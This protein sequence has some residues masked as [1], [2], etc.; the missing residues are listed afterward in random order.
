MSGSNEP[1]RGLLARRS[2]DAHVASANRKHSASRDPRCVIVYV[3]SINDCTA[4]GK[5][6]AIPPCRIQP[7]GADPER[8]RKR[9]VLRKVEHEVKRGHRWHLGIVDLDYD[10]LRGIPLSPCAVYTDSHD[11][12]TMALQTDALRSALADCLVFGEDLTALR[13]RLQELAL[14]IG[15][16][17]LR[18]LKC[19]W[20]VPFDMLSR[21]E[22]ELGRICDVRTGR[23]DHD[24]LAAWVHPRITEPHRSRHTV[25][26][27]RELAVTGIAEEDPWEV[28]HGHDMTMLL[29]LYAQSR[30]GHRR[31][32]QYDV[33]KVLRARYDRDEFRA[34]QM[35]RKLRSW[36]QAN[37]PYAVQPPCPSGCGC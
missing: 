5:V 18:S 25:L 24:A 35:H 22:A 20:N 14:P 1:R 21:D 34:T 36:E 4:Y 16:L 23:L 29:L 31:R 27:I 8:S 9:E 13:R 15:R 37:T 17:R 33:E 3:E 32:H 30:G 26:D 11:F 10:R 6:L 19:G 28:C 12:E 2:P 7:I